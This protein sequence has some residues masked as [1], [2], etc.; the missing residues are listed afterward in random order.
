MA[1]TYT[2]KAEWNN[3]S[4]LY[5]PELIRVKYRTGTGGSCDNIQ[6]LALERI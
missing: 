3:L 2:M 5:Q 6:F 4:G 1:V